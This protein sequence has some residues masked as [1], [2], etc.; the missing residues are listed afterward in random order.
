MKAQFI[1]MEFYFSPVIFFKLQYI[2]I[3]KRYIP[4]AINFL[5]GVLHMAI[6]KTGVKLIKVLKPFQA[7]STQLVLVE[8]FS[9][10]IFNDLKMNCSD[11][12]GL[13][14]EEF[15]KVKVLYTC[16]KILEEFQF[17]YKD[18]PSSVVIFNPILRYLEDIP[19]DKYPNVV[20]NIQI[21]VLNLLKNSRD[22]NKLHYI[23]MQ[24]MKPKAL[25]M[26]EPRIVEV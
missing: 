19:M 3:S 24:A 4:A 23:V 15:F 20:S 18:L 8:N 5:S 11:L 13:D 9:S 26:L 10:V 17:H 6:P 12:L 25:K 22:H 14:I 21:Q 2:S 7:I 16:I 1:C